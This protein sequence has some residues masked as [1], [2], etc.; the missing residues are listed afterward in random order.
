MKKILLIV[1]NDKLR[2]VYHEI[3]FSHRVEVIPVTE[4]SVA[5]MLLS[6]DKFTLVILDVGQNLLE[7]E[8]FLKLRK[9]YHN[10]SRVKFILLTDNKNFNP[11]L[12]KTDMLIYTSKIPIESVIAKIE[13]ECDF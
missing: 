11:I 10:L 7:T 5:I 4:L 8:V 13:K 12:S 9:K 6:L 1:T 3:L 2:Q